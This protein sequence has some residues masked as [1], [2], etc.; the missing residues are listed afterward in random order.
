MTNYISVLKVLNDPV[1]DVSAHLDEVG[2]HVLSQDA[3]VQ[4]HFAAMLEC[5]VMEYR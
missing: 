1:K 4:T 2:L 5:P 3:L